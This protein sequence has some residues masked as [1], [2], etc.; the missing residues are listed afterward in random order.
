MVNIKRLAVLISNKGTGSNLEAIL[1]AIE[2]GKIRNGK[3]VVVISDRKDAYGLIRAKKRGIPAVFFPLKEK[4]RLQYDEELGKMLKNKYKV[5]LVVLA[6]WMLILSQNFIKYFPN[7]TI[8][9]HPGLLPDKGTRGLHTNAAVQYAID[10]KYLV[11]G[12]TVH[13][14]TPKVDDG[15]VILR[16]EVK[17]KKGDTVESLYERMKKEEH[18]ILPKAINFLCQN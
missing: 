3:V 4:N 11:T 17:I 7:R 8:N 13:F 18:K 12:S 6:G 14:I 10:H 16:S 5:D 2:K 1:Q 15:R 9:L